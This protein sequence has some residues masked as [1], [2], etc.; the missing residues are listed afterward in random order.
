VASFHLDPYNACVPVVLL[1]A[2]LAVCL[3]HPVDLDHEVRRR[4]LPWLP[5]DLARQVLRHERDFNRGAAAAAAWPRHHHQPGAAGG[6][7]VTLQAQ[8]ERVAQAIRARA[9]FP[10]VVAGLGAVAHLCLDLNQSFS[11]PEAGSPYASSFSSLMRS[12][13]PRIP[14]VFYGQDHWLVRGP[15]D[16]LSA[17]LRQR[18]AEM[19]PLATIVRED[20]DRVGGPGRWAA[21]DD[22]SSSFGAASLVLNHAASDFANL[23]SW[24][25]RAAGGLVPDIPMQGN[26]LVWKGE[27]RPRETSSVIRIRKVGR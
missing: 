26:I 1:P 19:V 14:N 21:L 16:R 5:P 15:S 11:G 25:W 8:C 17:S 13:S 18:R 24:V 20:M 7:E 10:E 9:P 6:T 27:S 3:A 23:A 22:R 12:A 4:A 2:V